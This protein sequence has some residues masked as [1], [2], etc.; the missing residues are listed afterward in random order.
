MLDDELIS[1]LIQKKFIEIEKSPC[2]TT[3][4]MRTE[5]QKWIEPLIS[6]GMVE[7]KKGIENSQCNRCGADKEQIHWGSSCSRCKNVC[8]YCR[9]CLMMGKSS[10][11]SNLY[12]FS[13]IENEQLTPDGFTEIREFSQLTSAQNQASEKLQEFYVRNG[14]GEFLVWAVCGAGKT[15][16]VYPLLA[17]VLERKERILWATPRRDVVLELA[18]RIQQAFP[19]VNLSVLYG[20]SEDKWGKG[21]IVLSTTHQALRFCR[22]FDLVIVD[23][24]DAY[25]FTQDEMLPFAVNRACKAEGKTVYLT[26]TPRKTHQVRMGKRPGHPNYLPHVKIPVRYHGHPLPVPRIELETKLIKKI[27]EGKRISSLLRFLQHLKVDNHPGF[28]FI[29]SIQSLPFLKHYLLQQDEYWLGKMETVHATDPLREEKVL[30]M[31]QGELQVLLTTTILER[32]VTIPGIS[33]FVYQADAPI[34]DEAALVQIAGRAGRS[35]ATP[36]GEV[37]F[38]GEDLTRGM[39]DAVKQIKTM[40]RLAK[41]EGYF[42]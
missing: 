17:R 41:K 39:K 42:E 30:A 5:C 33:V 11:C 24:V 26:A 27:K 3:P 34:F 32:G 16:V 23:E 40:N 1:F 20:G 28:I 6:S 25:P 18:P 7:V 14:P 22:L 2:D 35:A 15:E 13:L 19:T 29:P 38:L 37:I 4:R 9:R 36:T 21:D 12:F 8:G 31:R 10:V